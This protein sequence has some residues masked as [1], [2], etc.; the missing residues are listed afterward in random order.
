MTSVSTI[1]TIDTNSGS[2]NAHRNSN[3]C[4]TPSHVS[5]GSLSRR[6]Q[7]LHAANINSINNHPFVGKQINIGQCP[8]QVIL[9]WC[10]CPPF[11]HS[12]RRF[13]NIQRFHECKYRESTK[14]R[15]SCKYMLYCTLTSRIKIKIRLYDF[16]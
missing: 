2:R 15:N 5:D 12:T 9:E 8:H 11:K 16:V 13:V 10:S 7:R 3:V 1:Q 14:C 4:I 6:A